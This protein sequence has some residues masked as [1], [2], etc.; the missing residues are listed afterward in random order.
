MNYLYTKNVHIMYQ[1]WIRA[2]FF[3]HFWRG[4]TNK[5][6][7]FIKDFKVIKGEF[8]AAF[9]FCPISYN[10]EALQSK[11]TGKQKNPIS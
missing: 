10:Q 8:L 1:D 9:E 11:Q 2:R 5:N 7:C 6:Q 4:S 3:K